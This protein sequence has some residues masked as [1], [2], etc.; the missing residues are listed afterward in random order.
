[1]PSL[2]LEFVHM[3]YIRNRWLNSWY[4]TRIDVFLQDIETHNTVN[5][6]DYPGILNED[7]IFRFSDQ[8]KVTLGTKATFEMYKV[9]QNFA[10]QPSSTVWCRNMKHGVK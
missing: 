1:M 4:F 8:V 2:R 7:D 3:E 6:E 5:D 9:A 10:H